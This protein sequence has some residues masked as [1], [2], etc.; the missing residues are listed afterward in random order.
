MVLGASMKIL[1]FGVNSPD[2]Q[3]DD[4][5][6]GLKQLD[7]VDVECNVNL[8]YLYDDYPGDVGALYGRGMSY[9]KNLDHKKRH[10]VDSK[11]I[12]GKLEGHY[13][14]AVVYLS[15]RRC[16]DF[17]QY[18][19]RNVKQARIA[20]V[21][22]EDDTDLLPE[23]GCLNFKRELIHA[24]TATLLPISFAIPKEKIC[25]G[26]VG[27]MKFLSE[28]TPYPNGAYRF[29]RENDYYNEYSSSRFAFTAKKAGWD[30][31][32]HY[33]ILANQCIPVFLG[34]DKCP[35]WTLHKWPKKLLSEIEHT[36]MTAPF[37]RHMEWRDSLVNHL[38]LELTTE[39]LAEYVLSKLF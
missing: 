33:E 25:P 19:R 38:S 2:Y 26:Y 29:E 32:R 35:E 6:H 30:C 20:L 36:F 31:K 15:I 34:I 21:D 4:L 39:K 1:A 11:E 27:K 22:G 5:Y 10:V 28:Q 8:S 16:N 24:P 9:A 14:D 23:T 37:S 13:Y 12:I 7:G 18:A 3:Q 17:I